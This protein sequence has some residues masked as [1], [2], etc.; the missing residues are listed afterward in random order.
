MDR[1]TLEK[2]RKYCAYQE[3]CHDEVKTKLATL[4]VKGAEAGEM[5]THLIEQGFLNEE[6][7]AKAFAGGKFRT[8]NWGRLRIIAELKRRHI[9][10]YCIR[11]ALQEIPDSDYRR[12]LEKLAQKA[13]RNTSATRVEVK[14]HKVAMVLIRKG[15]EPDATWAVVGEMGS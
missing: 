10:P 2:L 3:R 1:I 12:T 6:R 7:F 8:K 4:G 9:S 15:Y 5:I 11:M 14:R 13:W